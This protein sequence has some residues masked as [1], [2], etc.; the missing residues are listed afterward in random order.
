MRIIASKDSWIVG[1]AITQLE[2]VARLDGVVQ[3]VGMPDLHP[4]RGIP[5]GAAVLTRKVGYP[6]LAGNDIGCGMGLWRVLSHGKLKVQRVVKRLKGLELPWE[7]DVVAFCESCGITPSAS[8]QALGTIG[9]GNHFAELQTVDAV[10]NQ[11]LLGATGLAE[12]D[13][14]VLVHS[15]S[16]GLG[17]SVIQAHLQTCGTQGVPIGSPEADH[18]LAGHTRAVAWARCNRRLIAERFVQA[19][20]GDVEPVLDM[21]HNSVVAMDIDGETHWLHRKGAAPADEGL[22]VVPGSRGDMSYLI[23]PANSSVRS[24]FSVAHGAGRRWPRRDA[25]DRLERRYSESDLARTRLG[26]WVICEDRGLLYEEAPQAY[27]DIGRVVDDLV[28]HGLATVVA[29]LKPLITYKVS[30]V[31]R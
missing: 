21:C 4:G 20:G 25:R 31:E 13:T 17:E 8:D 18:Y 27:K 2:A 6:H 7:G 26:S 3:V 23:A 11:E 24:G 12:G 14:V 30:R 1:E 5:V 22:V 19:V 15:G 29:T 16:R 9:G 10:E 28:V